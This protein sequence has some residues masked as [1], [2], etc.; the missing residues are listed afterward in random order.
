MGGEIFDTLVSLFEPL[1]RTN[2][3]YEKVKVIFPAH[4]P[5][6]R[7]RLTL[8]AHTDYPYGAS[9]LPNRKIRTILAHTTAGDLYDSC[10]HIFCLRASI[11]FLKHWCKEGW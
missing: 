9:Y 6:G 8:F 11:S 5:Y 1:V 3:L 10:A 4:P 2:L 7:A